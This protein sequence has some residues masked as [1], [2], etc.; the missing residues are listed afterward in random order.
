MR[1]TEFWER[2]RHHLGAAYAESFA[3]DFVI[4]ELGGRTVH[5]ALTA[6]VNTK[7]VWRAV[8]TALQLPPTAR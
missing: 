1:H 5:E 4:A 8:C 7:D 6:G 2:M 3:R